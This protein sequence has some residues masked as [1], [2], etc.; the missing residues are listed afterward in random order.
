[1]ILTNPADMQQQTELTELYATYGDDE[2]N[3]LALTYDDLT[4]PAQQAMKSEYS[5]RHLTMP[6]AAAAALTP[7][8]ADDTE[9]ALHG[10]SAN[11]PEECVFEFLDLEEAL[12]AQSLLRSAGIP[13]V[14]PTSEILAIDTPRLIVGP[15]DAVAAQL[16]LSRPDATG[17][18][19]AAVFLEPTCP[20]CGAVDP[21]LES[22]EPT[23]HWHCE[24]CD[25]RWQDAL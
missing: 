2:L 24:S 4:D 5:R 25:N 14:V 18:A 9:S 16:I 7:I 20:K 12:L 6:A 8:E 22:V 19:D 1:V 3:T 21:I 15:S 17:D 23:N 11:A 13:S 10:F